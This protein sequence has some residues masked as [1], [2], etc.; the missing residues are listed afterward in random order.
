MLEEAGFSEEQVDAFDQ[1]YDRKC[2]G[3][4]L[5]LS[6]LA[7]ENAVVVKT[8][9]LH[10]KAENGTDIQTK[11]VDGRLCIVIPVGMGI[12]EVNGMACKLG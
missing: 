10:I 9:G 1:E 4:S 5:S 2:A 6:S 3:T 7:D 12:V 11:T 8:G